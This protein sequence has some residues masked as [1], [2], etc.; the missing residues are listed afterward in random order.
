MTRATR[1]LLLFCLAVGTLGTLGTVGTVGT[2]GAEDEASPRV[3]PTVKLVQRCAPAVVSL[4][5]IRP[6]GDDGGA[7][8]DI[9]SGSVIH[10]AG[11]ILTNLHVV[12]DSVRGE[13]VFYD[14]SVLPFDVVAGFAPEDLAIL[15][16][17][18]A[19]PLPALPIGRSD[20]L[21]LGEPVLVIGN[22]GG[23]AHTVT[24]GIVS[25]L[26]RVAA[27]PGGLLAGAIQTNA[28]INGGN[29][30]GPMINAL[31][32]QIGVINSKQNGADSIG[33]AIPIDRVRRELPRVISAEERFGF[34][35]GIETDALAREA[36]VNA[37]KS[38]SPAE[39]A[40]VRKGDVIRR[41]GEV[42]VRSGIDFHLA[43]I[44]RKGGESLTLEIR[45]EKKTITL[46]AKLVEITLAE[47]VADTAMT[48]GLSFE[49]YE[50][51]WSRLPD[52]GTVEIV[53]RGSIPK[54]MIPPGREGTDH[55]AVRVSGFV[56]VP[57]DG[58]YTFYSGSDDGSRLWIG[59]RRLA[60]NDG[61]H[62]HSEAAGLIRLKA[63]LHPFDVRMFEAS[64]GESLVVSW[65]GPGL[66]KR[67][68]PP[69]AFFRREKKD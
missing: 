15:R 45:R 69:E 36:I 28:A 50:G 19:K 13:A 18:A 40:G 64:G 22:P 61:L 14:G 31:G 12:R 10:S 33:F 20:D 57:K 4:R 56:K 8:L 23:L 62:A 43:L 52:L 63:G 39:A 38:G 68:I 66:S 2:L 1:T 30:G 34:R 35:L 17:R 6:V 11:W 48:P 42:A 24:T 59:G 54:P 29:S 7:V 5:S 26:G 51:S 55:F 60:D 58:V 49:V 46:T 53:G 37:V 47:P 9:G 25:G 44:G 21:L 27:T 16:V 67:E 3:T 65:E 41:L 32:Q